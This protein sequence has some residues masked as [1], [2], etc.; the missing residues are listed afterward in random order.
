LHRKRRQLF[1]IQS[2]IAKTLADQLQAKISLSEKAA[3]E[4]VPTTDLVAFDLYERA[5]ALWADVTDPLHA[6]KN[7]SEAAQLLNEAV[8]RDSQFLL[9]WCLLSRVHGALYCTGHDHTP[10]RLDQANEPVHT[11]LRLH[12]DA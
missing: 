10:P 4:K 1:S 8:A 9:A 7:L 12:P 6:Q 2:E 5:K 11:A 3:I